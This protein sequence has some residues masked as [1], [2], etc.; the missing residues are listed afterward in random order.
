MFYHH[1]MKEDLRSPRKIPPASRFRFSLIFTMSLL[2]CFL[3][4]TWQTKYYINC[5]LA[6]NVAGMNILYLK[7][8]RR[9]HNYWFP[10]FAF[11]LWTLWGC[12]KYVDWYV[13]LRLFC[14][15]FDQPYFTGHVKKMYVGEKTWLCLGIRRVSRLC[16]AD[17]NLD[18]KIPSVA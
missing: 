5:G 12:T 9:H 7:D 13:R 17:I 16:S 2:T 3:G 15:Q 11:P 6:S 1:N 8:G 18:K 14:I 4:F 10:A